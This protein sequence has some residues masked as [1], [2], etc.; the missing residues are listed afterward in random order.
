MKIERPFKEKPD[1]EHFRKTIM[2]E[3]TEGPVPI[4]ELFADVEIMA[5]AA[6]IEDF[7]IDKA[8]EIV[9]NVANGSEPE[10]IIAGIKI[11]D[12][13]L[14]FSRA[15]GYDYVTTFPSL[16]IPRTVYQLTN[17]PRQGKQRGWQN[18]H[19]GIIS[20]RTDF[21]N[22]PWPSPE[23]LIFF[24][25]DY[26]APKLPEGMKIMAFWMGIFEDLRALMGF[27]GMAIKSVEEPE[28][29]VDILERLTALNIAAVDRIAAHPA[30][31]AV[32]YADDLGFNN[33]TMLNPKF[34][35]QHVVSRI[36]RISEVCHKHGKPF[37]FHCCGQVDKIMMDLIDTAQIDAR[38]SFQDN[39]YKVE[40]QYNKYH[41]RIAIL[42]GL[43]VD[44]LARATSDEVR[45]RTREILDTCAPGGGYCMGSGNSVANF[46][47]IENYYA[48]IDETRKWNEEK[49]YF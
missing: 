34:M 16:P 39:A 8:R 37:L 12:L 17:N 22:F 27:E 38:H 35:R 49:G 46:C 43:D 42:G 26:I 14:E 30:V 41:D 45:K 10:T 9:M 6:G 5:E 21:D 31:G 28:L 13:Q 23:S 19:Q 20:N 24:P 40:D 44:L 7:P 36:K 25:I 32:F 2:R 29:C 11:L 47:K 4:I 1:F 33:G 18:E 15:V 48:M 3:T